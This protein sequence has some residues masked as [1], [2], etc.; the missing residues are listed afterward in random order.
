MEGGGSGLTESFH[1][2]VE[3]RLVKTLVCSVGMYSIE[4]RL[5]HLG[6]GTRDR[7]W[8]CRYDGIQE[9]KQPSGSTR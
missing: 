8:R 9:L 4:M 6:A 2:N 7:Q 3:K 5:R 1:V